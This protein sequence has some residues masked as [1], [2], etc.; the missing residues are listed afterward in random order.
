MKTSIALGIVAVVIII[1]GIALYSSGNT[2][3]K[4]SYAT[5]TTGTETQATAPATAGTKASNSEPGTQTGASVPKTVTVTYDGSSYSPSVVNIRTGDT[6]AFVDASANP[7]W[8]ASGVHP[9]HTLYDGSDTSAH[10]AA[11][12]AGPAPFDE[13]GASTATY[14]FT[15][16]EAGT[17]PYH[18]HVNAAATGKVVVE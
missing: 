2:Q 3:S 12:Y 9:T 11:D 14:T 1:G 13:C 16:T 6:V 18:N 8:V 15:F 10:C 4:P 17:H 5:P 7:M